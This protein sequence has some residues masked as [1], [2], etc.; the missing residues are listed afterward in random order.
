MADIRR[1]AESLADR[2][3]IEREIGHGGM[4]TVYVA[5]DRKHRRPLA[6]KVL[7]AELAAAL[8]PER[9]LREIE[10][11][12]RLNHPHILPV[13]DSGEAAG[14]LYYVMP[15]VDGETLRDRLNRETQLSVAEAVRLA[16]EVADGLNYAHHHGVIHRDIKPENI[17][18]SGGHAVVADFGIARAISEAGG[19]RLTETGITL[20]T[21]A[22]MSPEQGLG[23]TD[24]DGRSD[25]YSL[26]CVLY[27][28]LAGEPPHSGPT[29]QAVIAKRMSGTVPSVRTVREAVPEALDMVLTRA[30]ARVPADRFATV[31]ELADALN[32]AA[33]GPGWVAQPT[34]P[35]RAMGLY[36][37]TAVAVL[38]VVK[39]V[40][41][42]LG[43]PW[44]VVPGAIVLLLVG[45]PIILG[46]ALIQRGTLSI[47]RPALRL[48]TWRRSIA[49]G[50]LALGAWGVIVSGYML[51]ARHAGPVATTR[52]AVLPFPVRGDTTFGYLG[53][54]IVDLLSRNLDG[55]GT[56]RTVDPG[57]VLSALGRDRSGSVDAD[58]YR[59]VAR[60]VGAGLYLVGTVH[61]IGGRLRIQASLYSAA[62]NDPG[63]ALSQ[64]V[65]EGE[66]GDVYGVVD[67][68]A[69][70]LLVDRG[71][72]PGPLFETAT[73]TTRSLAALKSYLTAEQRLRSGP[74]GLDS[75]LAGL[76]RAVSEDSTFALAYYRLAVAAGWQGRH[77]VAASATRAALRHSD[78]LAER[79]RRLLRAYDRYRDGAVVQAEQEFRGLVRDYPDDLEAE[80]QLAD[81]L[82]YYNP[83]AGRSQ[84][85]AREVFDRVLA[86]DPGFL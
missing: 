40:A 65:E 63:V 32:R 34:G 11:A 2:Y 27:E 5:E 84:S 59:A 41:T 48:L 18:L 81:L 7:R 16:T 43:L 23:Q 42:Q 25:L 49:G 21:P 52:L 71:E 12:A 78:R 67:R 33:A 64:L 76:Q 73:L 35:L 28:M 72:A 15:F 60:R 51:S 62:A 24:I 58:R 39:L 14:F 79:D 20:G 46:T 55:A 19:D 80:F 38:A 68:L 77:E 74:Q 10:I 6:I 36:L 4:A 66:T 86:Y 57:T 29:T 82:S 85:E 9:F 47:P 45:I 53:D 37:L 26:G 1:L 50:V 56:L 83:L 75:A 3:A 61:A 54:G 70:Q 44:W 31:G 30:L 13:Y 8:G 22:Y 17:L 69:A